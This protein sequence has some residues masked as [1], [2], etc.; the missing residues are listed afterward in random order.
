MQRSIPPDQARD[1]SV[2]SQGAAEHCESIGDLH[3]AADHFGGAVEQYMLCLQRFD[4]AADTG[5]TIGPAPG[6]TAD[7][8]RVLRKLAEAEFA[9]SRFEFAAG[10]ARF[11]GRNGAAN[12]GGNP[13]GRSGDPG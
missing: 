10:R 7:R 6:A 12:L 1:R 2:P 8:V 9:R 13:H 3:F 4:A 11:G 5:P